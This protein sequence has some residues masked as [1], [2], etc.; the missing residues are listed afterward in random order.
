VVTSELWQTKE[1]KNP[2]ILL[3]AFN[4]LLKMSGKV[5]GCKIW[6]HKKSLSYFMR[7]LFSI[8][9]WLDFVLEKNTGLLH[10]ETGHTNHQFNILTQISGGCLNK[11][12]K[13]T[14]VVRH[15]FQWVH[16]CM[17]PK[18]SWG[19]PFCLRIILSSHMWVMD[20][21]DFGQC[22]YSWHFAKGYRKSAKS[23]H[24]VSSKLIV[25][26]PLKL[27][28]MCKWILDS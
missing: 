20:G 18:V 4:K 8:I 14:C 27:F 7:I 1:S 2:S 10:S 22:F 16:M 3:V 23:C 19:S 6:Q 15:I 21:Q 12:C 25:N 24:L 26:H 13:S 5:G 28:Q 17:A 11:Y 9:F